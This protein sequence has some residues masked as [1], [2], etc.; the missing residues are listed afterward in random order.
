MVYANARAFRYSFPPEFWGRVA[1]V[2]P[3]VMSAKFS[4]AGTLVE[5]LAA[6]E[7]RINFLPIDMAVVRFAE[8][9]PRTTTA[10]W[11]TAASMG[12]Q[13]SLAVMDAVLRGDVARARVVDADIAWANAP[14]QALIDSPQEFASYNIQVEKI[15]ID[16]SGYCVAGPIRPPY[17]VIPEAYARGAREC[18]RRW[19]ELCHKYGRV[20]AQP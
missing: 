15:R 8:L 5:S 11:A 1:K 9:A 14:I 13:P 2:A 20:E 3:T 19:A 7:E 6:S 4:N 18:G 12:P 16:A 17:D 10:C